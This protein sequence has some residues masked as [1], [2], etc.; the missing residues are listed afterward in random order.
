MLIT[1][2]NRDVVRNQV[3][4]LSGCYPQLQWDINITAS[5]WLISLIEI[6]ATEEEF[7]ENVNYIVKHGYPSHEVNIALII[8]LIREDRHNKALSQ[9]QPT[10]MEGKQVSVETFRRK[11]KEAGY[12][13]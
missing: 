2:D 5:A 12:G 10:E 1:K 6:K 8:K 9:W 13:K 11:V 3:I 4:Y 7:I